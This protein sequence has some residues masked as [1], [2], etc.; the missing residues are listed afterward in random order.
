[1][2][3]TVYWE[4]AQA[5]GTMLA[6]RPGSLDERIDYLFR[7]ALV[8]PPE[9][10]ERARL[11]AF[12]QTQHERLA[13]QELDAS[14]IAGPGEDALERAAWT[15]LARAILNLDETITKN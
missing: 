12:F 9:G 8:R 4:A 11:S 14:K 13:K 7:R 6:A 15:L 1:M 5:L 3:D 2:N 10:A